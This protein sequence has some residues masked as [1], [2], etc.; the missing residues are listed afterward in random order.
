MTAV[1]II[2]RRYTFALYLRPKQVAALHEH[3][4]PLHGGLWN[5]VHE[6]SETMYRRTGKRPTAYDLGKQ[7]KPLQAQCPEF[8][9]LGATCL[10]NT[11]R[12]Y[13]KARQS[14]F[15]RLN[16]WKA[17]GRKG[18]A[19]QPPGFVSTKHYPG[20]DCSY[21]WK[22]AKADEPGYI[23]T[24][25]GCEVILS[26][27]TNTHR[28][29]IKGIPGLIR[30]RGRFP[31]GRKLRRIRTITITRNH[32]TFTASIAV[33]IEPKEFAPDRSASARVELDLVDCFA[34]IF[35]ADRPSGAGPQEVFMT[36]DG[37]ISERFQSVTPSSGADAPETG[38]DQRHL[39][40]VERFQQRRARCR[41]G[42]HK[43]R[44]LSRRIR[45]T[46]ETIKRR[47]SHQMHE[48]TTHLARTVHSM[49]II[50]PASIREL[51]ASAT[52]TKDDPGAAVATVA[53]LNRHIL[54]Q[55]PA[56]FIAMLEYKFQSHPGAMTVQRLE[57]HPAGIGRKLSTA[58][59]AAKKV[60]RAIRRSQSNET[61]R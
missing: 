40:N 42:S 5:A 16:E 52:G 21:A 41:K 57:D 18:K 46:H 22:K 56:A 24:P 25:N 59:K 33:E 23:G 55:C 32:D 44:A 17:G 50:V 15:R 20:F 2:L 43:W 14:Y 39:K 47:R 26:S 8:K 9:A 27:D 38:T 45:R 35:R 60:R 1:D 12:R 3:C 48:F 53:K 58:K 10:A 51:T 11:I 49:E 6:I 37:R 7:I 36:P 19:P 28:L 34:R 54:S 29:R 13:D 4:G 30:M 31:R 61:S